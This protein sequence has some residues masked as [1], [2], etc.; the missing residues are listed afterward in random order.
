MYLDCETSSAGFLFNRVECGTLACI[1]AA[2][3]LVPLG[4]ATECG[5]P[6]TAPSNNTGFIP[7]LMMYP[8]SGFGGPWIGGKEGILESVFDDPEI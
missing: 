5:P 1:I 3:G 8:P 4:S 6:E 2:N 7:G